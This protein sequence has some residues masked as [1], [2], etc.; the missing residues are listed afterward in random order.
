MARLARRPVCLLAGLLIF[1]PGLASAA[2]GVLGSG[3]EQLVS[4]WEIQ[5]PRLSM[6]LEHH[7]KSPAG[8]P[9]VKLHL[10]EG[11]K[12]DQV[13][14]QLSGLGFRLVAQSVANKEPMYTAS[15][16]ISARKLHAAKVTAGSFS[17]AADVDLIGGAADASCARDG[18]LAMDVLRSCTLLMGRS[19]VFGRCT[20]P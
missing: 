9:L 16:K 20:T 14:P 7:L 1:I 12:L 3:L 17:V 13:L 18:V 11:I 6:V 2:P 5:D 10:A 15:G 8:D 4:A 19:R